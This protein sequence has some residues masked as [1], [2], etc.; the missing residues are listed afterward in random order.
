MA[1]ISHDKNGTR[2]I[3]F[4]DADGKRR[5]I[6]LGKVPQRL[7]QGIKL[8]VELLLAA[9]LMG[10]PIDAETAR[11]VGDLEPA[12][13]EKLAQVGPVPKAD[14]RKV[15]TVEAYLACWL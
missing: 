7:A 5:A 3:Q 12:F 1:S 6:R 8:R 4:V 15:V 14:P 2:R 10:H 13:N 11:W 9:K